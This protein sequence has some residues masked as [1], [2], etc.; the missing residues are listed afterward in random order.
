MRKERAGNCAIEI[1]GSGWGI[2]IIAY[3]KRE[4]IWFLRPLKRD[5]KCAFVLYSAITSLIQIVLGNHFKAISCSF[6]SSCRQPRRMVPL[7]CWLVLLTKH[8]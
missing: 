5:A 4:Y 1:E 2:Q 7:S 6:P 8:H 3:C